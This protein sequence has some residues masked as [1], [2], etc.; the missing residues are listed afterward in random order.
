MRVALRGLKV[1]RPLPLLEF[2][3]EFALEFVL[4]FALQVAFL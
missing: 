1:P 3:L 4:E 2:A